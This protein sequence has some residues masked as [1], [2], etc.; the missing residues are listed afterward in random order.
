MGCVWRFDNANANAIMDN[1]VHNMFASS[2]ETHQN[3]YDIVIYCI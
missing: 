3:F 2:G 1:A